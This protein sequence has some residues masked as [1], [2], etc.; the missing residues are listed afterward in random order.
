MKT[1]HIATAIALLLTTTIA[2]ADL[3]V[4]GGFE[5]LPLYQRD[6]DGQYILTEPNYTDII[7]NNRVP[8][9]DA[10]PAA[11]KNAGRVAGWYS[12]TT[13]AQTYKTNILMNDNIPGA[14]LPSGH[15][16]HSGDQAVLLN[17]DNVADTS[18]SQTLNTTI[19][20]EY[21]VSFWMSHELY[22]SDS[23]YLWVDVGSGTERQ[24]A[25]TAPEYREN[26]FTFIAIGGETTLTFSQRIADGGGRDDSILL[27]DVSVRAVPEPTTITAWL[28]VAVLGGLLIRRQYLPQIAPSRASS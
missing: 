18:I 2:K 1:I 25:S 13:S 12:T 9:A 26:Q 4:N 10:I 3:I 22:D 8:F 20:Q 17:G 5:E 11:Q 16:V 28:T 19:G 7:E 24:F 15:V 23:S 21:L 14:S 27:D 6:A